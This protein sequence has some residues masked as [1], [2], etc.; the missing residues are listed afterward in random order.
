MTLKQYLDL[1]S[2]LQAM[3]VINSDSQL[4]ENVV[5]IIGFESEEH[6]TA[7][8]FEIEDNT[9]G[10]VVQALFAATG[11]NILELVPFGLA[12]DIC[13]HPAAIKDSGEMFF[14]IGR[15]YFYGLLVY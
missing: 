3:P 8:F 4:I 1:N 11:Q 12:D 15:L 10:S 9:E 14:E 13:A 7:V 6:R 2:M 5:G